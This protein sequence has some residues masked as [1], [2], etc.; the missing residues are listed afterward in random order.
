MQRTTVSSS[1]INSIGY[2]QIS[3]TLEV[4][5][6]D[7]AI[8]HYFE[9]PKIKYDSLMQANSHGEYLAANI[10]GVYKYKKV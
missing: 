5:F 9:V 7:G 8:Y 2:D 6:S 4:E 10:K 3:H 1:N